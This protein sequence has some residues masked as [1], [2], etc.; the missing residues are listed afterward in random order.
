MQTWIFQVNP[1]RFDI[2]GY[3]ATAPILM[4]WLVTRY[5]DPIACGDRVFLWRSAGRKAD[6]DSGVVA[7][8]R[9]VAPVSFRPAENESRPYWTNAAEL[10]AAD[11][12]LLR[13][14]RVAGKREILKRKWIVEDPVL[15]DLAIVKMA[16][17]TNYA[18]L[19]EHVHRLESLWLKTGRDWNRAESVA[20]LWAYAKTYGGEVS[21]RPESVVARVSLLIGRAVGGVYNKVMN[22]RALDPRDGRDGMSG[23]G[24]TDRRVWDEFFDAASGTIRESALDA[25][26]ARLWGGESSTAQPPDEADAL[27][28]V[29]EKVAA[30]LCD[31][32]LD[33][34]IARHD[35]GKEPSAERPR[36]RTALARVYE[37]DPLVIAIAKK[38]AAHRCEVPGCSHPTFRD[39]EGHPYCEVHHIVPLA[40]GGADTLAN[41]ACLCPSHHREAHHGAE[42][43]S[44]RARLIALRR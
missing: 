35:R 20:G 9:V 31:V 14:L 36:T 39:E 16:N 2:D 10:A 21:K 15:R 13:V 42:A 23:G 38:R 30:R 27:A 40:D 1:A 29:T 19:A 4:T 32:P 28:A 6:A 41:T 7:E 12:V 44:L 18:V 3:L 8:M 26:F 22:F 11:R 17:A 37:R 43:G 34:L 24:V 5:G 33:E 25:E